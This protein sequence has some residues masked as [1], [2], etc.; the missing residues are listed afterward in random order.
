MRFYKPLIDY[1]YRKYAGSINL[2]IVKNKYL[3]LLEFKNIF[4][5]ADLVGDKLT[6]RDLNMAYSLSLI[7]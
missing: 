3:N 7:T 6:D 1:I 4:Y 5:E 2:E